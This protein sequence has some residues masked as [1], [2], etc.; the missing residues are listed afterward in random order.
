MGRPSAEHP[1]AGTPEATRHFQNWRAVR[2]SARTLPLPQSSLPLSVIP[3]FISS[4]ARRRTGAKCQVLFD[5]MTYTALMGGHR[6]GR[7]FR[8]EPARTSA[9]PPS[10]HFDPPPPHP[11][12]GASSRGVRVS[13]VATAE[14]GLQSEGPEASAPGTI[15]LLCLPDVATRMCAKARRGAHA[16]PSAIESHDQ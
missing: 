12:S 8:R 11:R 13:Y 9:I 4:S 3:Y 5:R 15:F 2:Q 1:A 16:Q 6:R 10:T 7:S 14:R